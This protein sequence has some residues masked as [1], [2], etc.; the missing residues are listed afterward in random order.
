MVRGVNDKY[1][2][3]GR[4]W[5]SLRIYLEG[6]L[7]NMIWDHVAFL[8]CAGVKRWK[9]QF[10]GHGRAKWRHLPALTPLSVAW[11][12]AVCAPIQLEVLRV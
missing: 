8:G 4:C 12:R 2:T 3:A 11:G 9:T 7:G 10:G 5:D 6:Q 1:I